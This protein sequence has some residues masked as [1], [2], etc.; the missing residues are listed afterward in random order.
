MNA[1]RVPEP[2]SRE[3]TVIAPDTPLSLPLA[4]ES[5][6]AEEELPPQPLSAP[7]SIIAARSMEML[8]FIISS[9]FTFVFVFCYKIILRK[10][11][12]M[13]KREFVKFK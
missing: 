7:V 10:F 4:W 5:E 11:C 2:S 8:F 6:E 1:P 9:P 12:K 3:I 13:Q